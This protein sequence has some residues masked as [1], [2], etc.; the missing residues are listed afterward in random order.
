MHLAAF[1]DKHPA[2]VLQFSSGKDSAA[3]LK[4]VE[5]YLDRITV[6]WV[7]PGDPYQE[8]LAYMSAV[9]ARVP[10]FV[11]AKGQQPAFVEANGYPV[12][13]VPFEGTPLGRVVSGSKLQVVP[14]ALCCSTNLWAPLWATV[15]ALGATGIINGTKLSDKYHTS[16]D[17]TI[18]LQGCSAFY[19]LKHWTDAQ[20][21]EYLGNDLPLSYKRGLES[22]LD[23]M[24]CTAYLHHNT[25]R[26][27]ELAVKYPQK[28]KQIRPTLAW[29]KQQ[30]AEQFS[31]LARLP[32]V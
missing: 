26:L 22:S 4:L 18:Q 8:T 3:C 23:C 17:E 12:D 25:V 14:L 24:T 32:E 31:S 13:L 28:Y 27:R 21:L 29:L 11:E 2:T 30:T 10:H 9:R 1:L 7:N 15:K 6:V 19:P 20:V 5:P 16:L